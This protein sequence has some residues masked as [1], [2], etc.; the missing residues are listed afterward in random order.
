MKLPRMGEP[1]EIVGGEVYPNFAFTDEQWSEIA[2]LGDIPL[3]SADEELFRLGRRTLE[4]NVGLYRLRK[5][6]RAIA[7][8][9]AEVRD[10]LAAFECFCWDWQKRLRQLEERRPVGWARSF[11][12]MIGALREQ[13]LKAHLMKNDLAAEIPPRPRKGQKGGTRPR[14]PEMDV[15]YLV[16]NAC[17]GVWR[18][19]HN[20]E[21]ISASRKSNN[22]LRKF[23]EMILR[24]A[25]PDIGD[26]TIDRAI[27]RARSR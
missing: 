24:I 9:P 17:V 27:A 12:K 3:L 4:V 10:E 7:M 22:R 8:S 6:L 25:D 26:A 19:Y 16:R 2:R 21:T 20:G 1:R 13:E 15:Y 11:G 18:E 23:I 14:R 5:R